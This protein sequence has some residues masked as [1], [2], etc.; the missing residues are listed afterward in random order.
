MKKT[1]HPVLTVTMLFLIM[2]NPQQCFADQTLKVAFG[3]ALPPWVIPETN[4]GILIDI[5]KETLEPAGYTVKPVY[6]PYARR[7]VTYKYGKVD[8]V[9]D[10]N[11]KIIADSKLKGYL[12]VIAYAYENIGVSLKKK[13]Y[14]FSG[15]SDLV[16]YSVVSWQG[17]KAAIGGEYA[18]MA[19]K[20]KKYRELAN[21]ELQIK[22]LY[23]EREDVI[24]LD[25]QIF[26]YF[27]KKVS[28]EGIIDTNQPVDIFP[29]FG[30][31]KCGF[32]FRDKNAQV[33]FD[34][35]FEI[36]KK[37]GRYDEIFE[38]HTQ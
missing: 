34:S 32:L 22:L 4:T 26:R 15:I 37:K 3:D 6:L 31:N 28:E 27:R 18:D 7:L 11:P 12:S 20:N 21:Q 17:A 9:C 35:N 23:A 38:K 25:R 24:Q 36:L 10:I 16:N 2:I 1:I 19:G 30:K 29:L 14:S 33:A 5:I 8:A 13:G